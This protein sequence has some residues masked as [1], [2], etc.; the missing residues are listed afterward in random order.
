MGCKWAPDGT[1]LLVASADC[2]MRLY[3]LP[4]ELYSG[5]TDHQLPEMSAVLTLSMGEAVYDY[6]WYPLMSSWQP[7]TACFATTCKDHPVQLW[8][9]F[10]LQKRA[11]YSPHNQLVCLPPSL[12][13]T[14]PS[15]HVQDELVSPHALCFSLD[16]QK[17]FCGFNKCVRMFETSRPGRE[18]STFPTHEKKWGGQRGIVS[19]IAMLPACTD[20]YAVGCYSG[21]VGV[22]CTASDGAMLLLTG[23]GGGVTHITISSDGNFLF[24]GFRKNDELKVWDIRN[25]GNQL[26]Q[27]H[28]PVHTNQRM[29]FDLYRGHYLL[30]GSADGEVLAWD[31]TALDPPSPLLSHSAHNDPVTGCSVHPRLPLLATSSGQR[32]F[33]LPGSEDGDEDTLP[34]PDNSLKLWA[35]TG[36]AH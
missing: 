6:C 29:Y 14:S 24:V 25:P 1:C 21:Q 17:L 35:L 9:A 32:H 3:N 7:D 11:S 19:C 12:P 13:P 34:L 8:D 2:K 15:C 26:A 10:D 30:S 36:Q 16:G 23:L 27:L 20:T 31:T 28:R 5:P 4:S 22:Y 18:C 33:P